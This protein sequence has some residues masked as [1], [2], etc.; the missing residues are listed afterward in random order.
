MA[1][2][3]V[4]RCADVCLEKC[5]SAPPRPGSALDRIVCSG[6]KLN[7][8]LASPRVPAIKTPL[9]AV[10]FRLSSLLWGADG[11]ISGALLF[12]HLVK[13]HL[14]MPKVTEESWPPPTQKFFPESVP[15]A[16]LSLVFP[17][18]SVANRG[19]FSPFCQWF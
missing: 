14:H 13:Y 8:S 9:Q 1:V 4:R 10:F 16:W 12:A 3:Q 18:S 6:M 19:A 11:C 5:V 2:A 7:W 15:S 17:R